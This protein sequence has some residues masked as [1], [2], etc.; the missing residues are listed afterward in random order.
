MSDLQPV[1]LTL[2]L[3]PLL[4]VSSAPLWVAGFS[5]PLTTKC[6]SWDSSELNQP[7]T[8]LGTASSV[9]LHPRAQHAA[10]ERRSLAFT[11]VWLGDA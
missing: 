11:R 9:P 6:W 4:H 5:P 1:V 2:G 7:Q 3:Q 10:P 8:P